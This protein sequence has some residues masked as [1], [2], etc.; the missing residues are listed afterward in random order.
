MI[1]LQFETTNNPQ[2]YTFPYTVV[3][4]VQFPIQSLDIKL[5][6]DWCNQFGHNAFYA[7]HLHYY[8]QQSIYNN[9]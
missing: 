2:F 1:K 4:Q 9:Q 3:L 6:F 8:T 5:I 7:L